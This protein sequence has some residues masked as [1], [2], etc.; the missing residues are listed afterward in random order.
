MQQETRI[1]DWARVLLLS[2]RAGTGNKTQI[3]CSEAQWVLLLL[4]LLSFWVFKKFLPTV[5]RG[6]SFSD[7]VNESDVFRSP[8]IHSEISDC[9]LGLA[10]RRVMFRCEGELR[11]EWWSTFT[12]AAHCLFS[13]VP[14]AACIQ[15]SSMWYPGHVG[16]L[17]TALPT[18]GFVPCNSDNPAVPAVARVTFLKTYIWITSFSSSKFFGGFPLP[19]GWSANSSTGQIEPFITCSLPALPLHPWN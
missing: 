4:L 15:A 8:I 7:P 5:S 2:G 13:T 1:R 19:S 10:E 16:H 6:H 3:C 14:G 17:L 18:S 9:T 11:N 12:S